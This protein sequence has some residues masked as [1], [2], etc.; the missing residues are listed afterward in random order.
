MRNEKF[1]T[2][3][4]IYSFFIPQQKKPLPFTG[5]GFYYFFTGKASSESSLKKS[6]SKMI[7]I[8]ISSRTSKLLRLKMLYTFVRSQGIC[9][10]NQA[11]ERPCFLRISSM[12]LPIFILQ[13]LFSSFYFWY[14]SLQR[15]EIYLNQ[16]A[17]YCGNLLCFCTKIAIFSTYA[18]FYTYFLYFSRLLSKKNI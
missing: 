14:F 18:C 16:S 13:S 7:P 5:N 4:K 2:T 11:A 10:A 1:T 15:Y 6:Y 9:V 17:H 8:L 3:L 12:C